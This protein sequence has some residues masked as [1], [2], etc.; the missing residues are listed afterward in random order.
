MHRAENVTAKIES[1]LR[2]LNIPTSKI[3]CCVTDNEPTNNAAADLME[4][5]W[6]GCIDH[7]IELTTGMVLKSNGV[8]AVMA[9]A[10]KLVGH[11]SS[12]NQEIEQ[13]KH[14]QVA[15]KPNFA[16]KTVIQ[17]V[18]TRWW[19]TYSMLS[20]LVYL[21]FALDSMQAQR[22]ADTLTLLPDEWELVGAVA[23]VLEPF[24][25]LQQFFEGD[26]YVTISFIPM[27]VDLMRGWIQ[28]V[29]SGDCEAHNEL[30]DSCR[31]KILMLGQEMHI[32]F[33]NRWGTGREGTV[34][35]GDVIVRG[36][37]RIR[38]G[39]PRLTCLAAAIDPR[40]KRLVGIPTADKNAIW[41]A[42]IIELTKEHELMMAELVNATAVPVESARPALPPRIQRVETEEFDIF[43]TL[44]Q[45]I[46]AEVVE[47][48]ILPSYIYATNEVT[49]YKL[50]AVLPHSSK[51]P[52]DPLLWWK[53]HALSYPLMSRVMRRLLNIPATS[54]SSE[55][56]FSTSGNVISKKRARLSSDIASA[57]VFLHGAWDL[58]E[59]AV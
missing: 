38:Q 34:W 57:I 20:R 59:T 28:D 25:K 27:M 8:E 23:Q 55:R 43:A 2:D 54:A 30:S 5:P 48:D 39:I 10:R 29:S 52:G 19:S 22:L 13:L 50:L 24:M 11:F 53:I 7:L 4:F 16:P 37:R 49:S 1:M 15:L 14:I 17:D 41:D 21:R 9:K 6:H 47:E 3:S 33:E 40:T 51:S 42:L 58:S 44:S 18:V 26:Q 31:E 46:H 32:S 36:P 12:S 45:V 35:N 56:T